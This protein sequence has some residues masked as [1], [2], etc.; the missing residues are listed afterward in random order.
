MRKYITASSRNQFGTSNRNFTDRNQS[1]ADPSE[2]QKK[3]MLNLYYQHLKQ[4]LNKLIHFN[5]SMLFLISI[6]NSMR[7]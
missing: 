4:F 6:S 5:G 2:L 7:S 1:I 3:S